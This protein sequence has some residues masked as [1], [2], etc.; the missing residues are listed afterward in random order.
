MRA[1]APQATGHARQ[2]AGEDET[3]VM[4]GHDEVMHPDAQ[5]AAT[6]GQVGEFEQ[7]ARAM[8]AYR[9]IFEAQQ[10]HV[11]KVLDSPGATMTVTCPDWCE[12]DHAEDETHGTYLEDFGHRGHEEA[13][14]VDLGDGDS[15]D[16]LL[17]EIT[18]Y[19]F[20]RDLRKPTAL[21]WPTLDMTE[22]HLDPDELAALGAQ[23]HEYADALVV[24]SVRLAGIR[25]GAR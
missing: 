3:E 17:C 21:L 15:E 2:T 11:I 10:T 23:L 25:K 7:H 1:D 12:S 22:G 18:Q 8:A 6:P 9:K 4:R 20:G 24:M 13:L 14:H 16:V 5:Q 19:P